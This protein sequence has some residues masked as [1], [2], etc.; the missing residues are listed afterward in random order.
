MQNIPEKLS[1]GGKRGV[2]HVAHVNDQSGDACLEEALLYD[3]RW[4]RCV[5]DLPAVIAPVRIRPVLF[6]FNHNFH[7]LDLLDFLWFI[8]GKPDDIAGMLADLA[9]FQMVIMWMVDFFRRVGGK[10]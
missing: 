7:D 10:S 6:F 5:M 3:M 1:D 9:D 8:V 4:E 2:T